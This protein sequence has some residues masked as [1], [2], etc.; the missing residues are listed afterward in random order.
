[1]RSSLNVS[2]TSIFYSLP[3]V[4]KADPSSSLNSRCDLR[5]SLNGNGDCSWRSLFLR[6]EPLKPYD[7]D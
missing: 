6:P 7:K 1:M 5:L 3:S 4:G 2:S